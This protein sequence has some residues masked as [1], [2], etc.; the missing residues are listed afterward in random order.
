MDAFLHWDQELFSI[1]NG[2]YSPFWDFVFYY[3]GL[4]LT[5]FPLYIFAAGIIFK[6]KGG[7]FLI[8]FLCM[9]GVLIFFTEG[10]SS[11]IFKPFFERLRPCHS[12]IEVHLINQQCGGQFGF[13]SAHAANFFGLATFIY[14]TL[15]NS[16]KFLPWLFIL[17][18][19]I[20]SYG[21]IYAGV[22]WPFDVLGGA[23]VGILTG[24]IAGIGFQ[25]IQLKFLG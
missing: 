10:I 13:V 25:K 21:R 1:I 2:S 5:W 3:S 15:R 8:Y 19:L 17:A 12:S 11:W 6:K 18:A 24:F 23:V 4:K 16:I 22:H 7:Q 14:F 20:V 9:T